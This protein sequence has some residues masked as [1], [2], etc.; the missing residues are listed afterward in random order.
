MFTKFLSDWEIDARKKMPLR[1]IVCAFTSCLTAQEL[2]VSERPSPPV[3]KWHRAEKQKIKIDMPTE[4]EVFRYNSWYLS[5]ML[6]IA[7]TRC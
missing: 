5:E 1:L 4:K 2:V 6:V 3:A 7:R